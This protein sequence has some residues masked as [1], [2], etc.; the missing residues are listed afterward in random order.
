MRELV[1]VETCFCRTVSHFSTGTIDDLV[2]SSTTPSVLSSSVC[3]TLVITLCCWRDW[4]TLW[5]GLSIFLL[6]DQEQKANGR[7]QSPSTRR[8]HKRHHPLPVSSLCSV[9]KSSS[10]SHHLE[11]LIA[12]L[13]GLYPTW[14]TW[15]NSIWKKT[16][17]AAQA[18]SGGQ[19]RRGW[20]VSPRTMI[21]QEMAPCWK[22]PLFL[23]KEQSGS[24][25]HMS[26]KPMPT[27]SQPQPVPPCPSDMPNITWRRRES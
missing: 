16:A 6:Q 13:P 22:E 3:P 24:W 14:Q 27:G 11:F 20:Q 7:Q 10:E 19:T 18:C 17:Q 5:R 26:N 8:L 9:L 1:L 21:G 12:S 15:K 25:R 4:L 23:P 2:V